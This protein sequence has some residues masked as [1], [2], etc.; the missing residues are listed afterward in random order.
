MV[1]RKR[2]IMSGNR[3]KMATAT[4]GVHGDHRD[5]LPRRR[6]LGGRVYPAGR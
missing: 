3:E 1:M 5:D 4:A 2:A 6:G